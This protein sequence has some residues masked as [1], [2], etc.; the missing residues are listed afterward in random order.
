M[1]E[2]TTVA[3]AHSRQT[4]RAITLVLFAVLSAVYFATISGI[5][6]SNDGSHYALLRTMV[7][8]RA[9][10]LNQFDDYAEGNDIAVTPD[11]RLFSD[12][13]PGTALAAIP[14]YVLG[15]LLP[16]APSPI[17]SRH[18]ADNPRMPYALL[19]PVLAAAGTAALLY[20]LLR[21][22]EIGRAAALT[23][24]VFFALGTIHWKYG[25]VLYSHALS[26][27]LV[28]LSVYLVLLLAD[29]RIDGWSWY[30][31]LGFVLGSAVVVEYSNALVVIFTGLYWVWRARLRVLRELSATVLPWLAGGLIPAAFL[32]RYNAANF[33]SPLRLSYAYAVNYPWAGAFATTFN[34]PVWPGLVALLWR[35][36][37]GGWC[38]GPCVNEGLFPLS[39]VM[40]LALPGAVVFARRRPAAFLLT[41]ALFLVYLLL[42]AKHQT[43]HG[44]TGDGRYLAPFLGLLVPALGFA[45]DWLF[46][47]ARRPALR[48]LL[49]LLAA[50]LFFV[51]LGRQMIHIGT[52]YNYTLDPAQLRSPLAHPANWPDILRA[53]FP[54]TPNLA[55]L[56]LPLAAITLIA[57]LRMR[58]A[59]R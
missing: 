49:L 25:T 55:L 18:D 27:F 11:G 9:F 39:P 30:A 52:S 5:T 12:R 8:N 10:S 36:E 45:L 26:G 17:P 50:G 7:E 13:P 46:D 35:G 21:Y 31:L 57:L 16:D 19:M 3:E 1:T 51:S 23:A 4:D 43:S 28:T 53:V 42:F 41:S 14:F 32:A 48:G 59:S 33:G 47:S 34:F 15:G 56:I 22:L 2:D 37:G 38:G 20:A 40:L 24:V 6:S 29:R 54:N 58:R 44:F